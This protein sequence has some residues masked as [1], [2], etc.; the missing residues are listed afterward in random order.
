MR[1][2]RRSKGRKLGCG[3]GTGD[4]L[5]RPFLFV[6]GLKPGNISATDPPFYQLLDRAATTA[7]KPSYVAGLRARLR[8]EL[9]RDESKITILT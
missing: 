1:R 8:I 2:W 6:L 9:Q 5:K 3:V 4:G 7:V